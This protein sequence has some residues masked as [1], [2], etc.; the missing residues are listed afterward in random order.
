MK[1]KQLLKIEAK[2][3]ATV[4]YA[5]WVNESK[6]FSQSEKMEFILRKMRQLNKLK[7]EAD[8]ATARLGFFAR[9]FSK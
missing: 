1:T 3:Q 9:K 5:E 4:D 2:I 8:K 6:A 7:D